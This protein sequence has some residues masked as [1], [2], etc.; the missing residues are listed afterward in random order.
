MLRKLF[1]ES[2]GLESPWWQPQSGETE[3][4]PCSPSWTLLCPSAPELICAVASWCRWCCSG[5]LDERRIQRGKISL[6]RWTKKAFI[7]G[8][9]RVRNEQ[10]MV[11]RAAW[12]Q[13]CCPRCDTEIPGL[14]C[15]LCFFA[16]VEWK[17]YNRESAH[18]FCMIAEEGPKKSKWF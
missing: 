11:Y 3:R 14:M 4:P 13:L 1:W 16:S 9:S 12:G 15:L 2:G 8:P 6:T 17:W 10:H 7:R 18:Q 5:N